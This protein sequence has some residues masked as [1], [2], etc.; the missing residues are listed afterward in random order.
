MSII[1]SRGYCFTINNPTELDDANIQTL[2]SKSIYV[3]V[4]K[5][6][7]QSGTPHY[8]GYVW[9]TH[10][11]TFRSISTV[12]VRAHIEKAKA[13]PTENIAYCKKENNFT[14]WGNPPSDTN[15]KRKWTEILDMAEAGQL[16][17]IRDLHPNVYLRYCKTLAT[18]VRP[19]HLILPKLENEWWYGPTGLGKSKELHA[20]YRG[21]YEKSLN[22]WWD[23]YLMQDVVAIEEWSPKNDM[24]AAFLKRWADHYP[25]TAEI[26]GGVMT[27][28]RPKKIIVT[29]NF[30]MEQCFPRSEDLL[31]LK[32]RFKV[33]HWQPFF[34]NPLNAD[35]VN[36]QSDFAQSLGPV[37]VRTSASSRRYSSIDDFLNQSDTEEQAIPFPIESTTDH[38]T[39]QETELID[40]TQSDNE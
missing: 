5:E 11:V 1:R 24:T 15:Q 27:G 22:K 3:I 35:I 28:I 10:A 13:G 17:E 12:L 39:T 40:L 7:G 14:E 29:S 19:P 6:T 21:F 18:L 32:R 23:G 2:I 25:F 36:Q 26:K 37:T 9:F 30:T 4:G 8:Q 34:A 33:V 38:S 20:K 16:R 31:P